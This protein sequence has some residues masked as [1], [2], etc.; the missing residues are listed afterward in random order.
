M[1]ELAG[2]TAACADLVIFA[3]VSLAVDVA[4][5]V[6]QLAGGADA[7]DSVLSVNDCAEDDILACAK[8]GQKGIDAAAGV[9]IPGED[10]A[11]VDGD[12]ARCRNGEFQAC[13]RLGEQAVGA[14]GMPFDSQSRREAD[15]CSNGDLT[16]ASRWASTPRTWACRWVACPTLPTTSM[17]AKSA[18]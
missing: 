17:P 10:P 3:C 4:G 2:E 16:P 15:A 11:S 1:L 6:D 12:N 13:M 5:H 18:T 8:L 7:A 9:T 14:G